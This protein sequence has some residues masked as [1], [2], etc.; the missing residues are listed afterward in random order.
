MNTQ[1]IAAADAAHQPSPAG[2]HNDPARGEVSAPRI[3][4]ETGLR[5]A[6]RLIQEWDEYYAGFRKTEPEMPF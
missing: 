6:E 5:R 4:N 3:D 2:D 1:P